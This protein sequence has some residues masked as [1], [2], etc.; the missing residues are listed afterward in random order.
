MSDEVKEAVLSEETIGK[1]KE[2]GRS[3]DVDA[4]VNQL[5]EQFMKMQKQLTMVGTAISM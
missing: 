1:L 5:I 2:M 4:T 3:E